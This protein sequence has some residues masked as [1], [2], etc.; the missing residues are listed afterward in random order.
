MQKILQLLGYC[1]SWLLYSNIFISL[2]AVALSEATLLSIGHRGGYIALQVLVFAATLSVYALHRLIS[3]ERIKEELVN[4]RFLAI[5]QLK[6]VIRLALLLGV[7]IGAVAFCF[8]QTP[9]QIALIVP[10]CLSIGY[11]LPFFRGKRLRDLPLLKIFL[12]AAVWAYVTVLLPYT[13]TGQPLN[14]ALALQ[15][16][17]R[18]AF[19]FAITIPFDI[20]D[21]DIEKVNDVATLPSFLG[22]VAAIRLSLLLLLLWAV[23]VPFVYQPLSVFLALWVLGLYTAALLLASLKPRPDYFFS[24]L[25]DGT[26]LMY[27]TICMMAY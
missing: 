26:M 3:L 4:T 1:L 21:A 12:I 9:T 20:R 19:I 24:G 23:L 6:T 15:L 2:C 17:E 16:I 13:E 14:A 8:L 5:R 25:L 7:T 10:A 11:V 27:A 18:A 22:F